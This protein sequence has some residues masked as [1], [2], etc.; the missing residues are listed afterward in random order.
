VSERTK[1]RASSR[2]VRRA[3]ILALIRSHEIASQAELADL[4][5]D[6]GI[7]VSQGTLSRDLVDLGAVRVRS[8]NGALVYAPPGVEGSGRADHE[9]RLA[10]IC[11]E[12]LLGADSSANLTVLTTPPGAAQ[13]LASAID[14]AAFDQVVGTIAGDDTILVISRDPSGGEALASWFLALASG[15]R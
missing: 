10:R 15:A 4:L 3:R 5:A 12:A 8:E 11:S 14:R 2:A 7:V 6:E 1:E 13:Y 9:A